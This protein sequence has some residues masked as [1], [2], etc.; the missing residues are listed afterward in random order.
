VELLCLILLNLSCFELW[1]N[2]NILWIH[3][4][5]SFELLDG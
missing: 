4:S 1:G 5:W 2:I 3:Y